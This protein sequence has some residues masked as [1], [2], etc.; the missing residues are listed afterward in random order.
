MIPVPKL[1][2]VHWED[3]KVTKIVMDFMPGKPL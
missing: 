2:D 3:G 1:H